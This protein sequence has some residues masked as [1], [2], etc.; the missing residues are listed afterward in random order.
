ME[1]SEAVRLTDKL[2]CLMLVSS[3]DNDKVV[4]LSD[5]GPC[6]EC[7]PPLWR[8]ISENRIL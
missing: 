6:Y 1:K 2:V 8:S 3:S 5:S 7:F 4:V